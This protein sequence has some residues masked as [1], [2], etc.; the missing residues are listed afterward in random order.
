[1]VKQFVRGGV[2]RH[3]TSGDLDIQVVQVPYFDD[4]RI[5]LKV[6]WLS[7]LTGQF[8]YFP[9]QQVS[10]TSNIEIQVSDLI[11]WSRLR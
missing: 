1:M 9:E 2:Y 10:G 7:K 3:D 4:K 6:K 5:K 8:V 11:Y